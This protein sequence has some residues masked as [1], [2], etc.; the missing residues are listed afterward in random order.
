MKN[1][2][3]KKIQQ[4]STGLQSKRSPNPKRIA[5]KKRNQLTLT[6]FFG[7]DPNQ[8]EVWESDINASG[9]ELL[10]K[11]DGIMRIALQ[12]PNGIKLGRPLEIMP[13]VAAISALQIDLAGFPEANLKATGQTEATMKAQLE[14]HNS[15]ARIY[16]ATSP[17]T[18]HTRTEYQPGGALLAILD[19]YTG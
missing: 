19:R 6:E 4:I 11:E 8:E 2:R 9:D 1:A 14:L 18:S 10:D 5:K 7:A 16:N 13:E 12:N 17:N 15:A 3:R